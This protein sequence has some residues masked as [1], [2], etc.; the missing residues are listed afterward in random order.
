MELLVEAAS[1]RLTAPHRKALATQLGAWRNLSL[2][3]QGNVRS[4]PQGGAWSGR[5]EVAVDLESQH[6]PTSPGPQL[7]G[8]DRSP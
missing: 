7:S 8:E 5:P 4:M 2:E 6:G 3:E 1:R